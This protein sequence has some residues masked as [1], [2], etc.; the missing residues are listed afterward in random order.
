MDVDEE[1]TPMEDEEENED[2]EF[3]DELVKK[4]CLC[5]HVIQPD[6]CAVTYP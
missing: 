3:G 6:S 5:I 2:D 1:D 4:T